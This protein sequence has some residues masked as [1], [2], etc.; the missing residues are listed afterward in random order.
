VVRP[1]N[2]YDRRLLD[3]K[4]VLFARHYQNQQLEEHVDKAIDTVRQWVGKMPAV[5]PRSPR[6][7]LGCRRPTTPA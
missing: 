3:D 5:N 2:A 6:T 7:T 4:I 1:W